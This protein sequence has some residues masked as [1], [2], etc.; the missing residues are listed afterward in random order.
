MNFNGKTVVVTG[1]DGGI[2][3]A[4]ARACADKGMNVVIAELNAEAGTGVAN[5]IN[6][7]GKALFVK[8]DVGSDESANTCAAETIR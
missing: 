7:N 6:K 8:T 5:D 1:S 2:G 4:Y 3:E